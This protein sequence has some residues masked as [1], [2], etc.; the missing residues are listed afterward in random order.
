MAP[1]VDGQLGALAVRGDDGGG[2]ATGIA[3]D[4]GGVAVAVGDGGQP[5]F[6]VAL[7][8]IQDLSGAGVLGARVAAGWIEKE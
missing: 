3:L 7:E 6:G 4:G 8:G 5:A 1:V 2:P